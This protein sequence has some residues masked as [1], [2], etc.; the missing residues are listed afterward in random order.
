LPLIQAD[1]H[2][3]TQVFYNLVVNALKFTQKGEVRIWGRAWP[4]EVEVN[5]CDTGCGIRPSH[6][7]RIFEPFEQEESGKGSGSFEG[8][9]LGLSISR[10]VV[11]RHG[12]RITVRSEVGRGST[13]TVFL[14]MHVSSSYSDMKKPSQDLL[15]PPPAQVDNSCSSYNRRESMRS[16]TKYNNMEPPQVHERVAPVLAPQR[17]EPTNHTN[18]RSEP[19]GV[20][21]I[22]ASPGSSSTDVM[23]LAPIRQAVQEILNSRTDTYQHEVTELRNALRNEERAVRS[24]RAELAATRAQL[25]ATEADAEEAWLRLAEAERAIGGVKQASESV[26]DMEAV[27]RLGA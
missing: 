19:N 4:E 17:S 11:Q 14:P 9:G 2:R 12:G 21:P 15:Q 20:V 22:S 7:D 27:E 5:V 18:H 23:S 24:C 13:F 6:V 26:R 1:V 8:I 16:E 25:S 10:E 3:C